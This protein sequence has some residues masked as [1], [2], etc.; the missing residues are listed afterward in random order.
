MPP[1]PPLGEEL[2]AFI[3]KKSAARR[4][5]PRAFVCEFFRDNW[6][7]YT[8]EERR[9]NWARQVAEYPWYAEDVL[10]CMDAVLA[11]PPP[12]LDEQLIECGSVAIEEPGEP[13]ADHAAYVQWLR[14]LRAGYGRIYDAAASGT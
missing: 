7:E 12:D 13:Q 8:D 11:D 5:D 14:D 3:R 1:Q 10:V 9:E 4:A 6:L 2:L